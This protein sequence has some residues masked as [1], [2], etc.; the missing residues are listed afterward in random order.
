MLIILPR[1]IERVDAAVT[2]VHELRQIYPQWN[3]MVMDID[4]LLPHKLNTLQ[5]P[6]QQFIRELTANAFDL[7][8][9]LNSHLDIRI[10]YLLLMLKIPY[11]VHLAEKTG[12]F[13]NILVQP[14]SSEYPDFKFVIHYMEQIF[15]A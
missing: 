14:N 7:V 13:Y 9:D 10:G 2:L 4:K 6:N 12:E 8:V 11:R 3:F 15:T 5:L 1:E